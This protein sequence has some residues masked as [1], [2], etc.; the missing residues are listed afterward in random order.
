MKVLFIGDIH[1]R[2]G[3]KTL[4]NNALL[5]F[6]DKI[7]FLGDY[8]DSYSESPVRQ[9]YNLKEIVAF[10]RK[11]G[12]DKVTLL[13]GNH[14]YAYIHNFYAISGF[15]PEMANDFKKVF[16]ENKDLFSIAWGHFG[17]NGKYTLATHAGL[18]LSFYKNWLNKEKE[19]GDFVRKILNKE[20]IHIHEALNVLKDK[21]DLM[22]KV[23]SMRGGVGT[24]GVLW[25][26]NQELLKDPYPYINQI[27]GHTAQYSPTINFVDEY[28]LACIDSH[29]N[30]PIASLIIDL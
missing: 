2:T 8:V 12:K 25:A 1:G 22:W 24:P 13:L 19:E 21:K 9:L 10:K 6:V 30:S 27:Y 11:K 18:T 4:V 26:D 5:N 28:I 16:E 20:N 15:Q 23:G 17:L 14:D 29:D 3:W 7:V